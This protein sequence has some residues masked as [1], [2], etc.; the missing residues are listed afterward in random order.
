MEYATLVGSRDLHFYAYMLMRLA[1]EMTVDAG[2][3]PRSGLAPGA[4]SAAYEGARRSKR[5]AEIG[6]DNYLPNARMFDTYRYGNRRPNPE[7]RIY[8]ATTFTATYEQA[9][10]HALAA[11][12]S[13]NGLGSDGILLHTRNSFQVLGHEMDKPS[14]FVLCW[15]EPSGKQGRVKGGT[16][17]AVMIGRRYQIPVRNMY[18]QHIQANFLRKVGGRLELMSSGAKEDFERCLKWY[19][20][21]HNEKLSLCLSSSI[22][23]SEP[24][25]PIVVNPTDT[26]PQSPAPAAPI[27]S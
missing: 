8:D 1:G 22:A 11:R 20:H 14:K 27:D 12:G 13:F 9:R 3:R 16:N 21:F 23:G 5:F 19:E 4:D 6:F 17:T 15:A 2:V 10:E 7:Q 25:S 18:D 26:L 24:T